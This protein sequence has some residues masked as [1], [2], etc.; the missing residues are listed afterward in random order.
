MKR[1]V[2][3]ESRKEARGG[4]SG[5]PTDELDLLVDE[6]DFNQRIAGF[7]H[8]VKCRGSHP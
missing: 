4:D 7:D 5:V 8:S 3:D 6:L 2:P 1:E